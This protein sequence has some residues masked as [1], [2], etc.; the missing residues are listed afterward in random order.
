M[1]TLQKIKIINYWKKHTDT[2]TRKKFDLSFSQLENI[3]DF[4]NPNLI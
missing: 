2:Q 3:I 4:L 1:N